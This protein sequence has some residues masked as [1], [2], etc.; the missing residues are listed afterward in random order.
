MDITSWKYS[1]KNKIITSALLGSLLYAGLAQ[2]HGG[3]G[4][5]SQRKL[6]RKRGATAA[7]YIWTH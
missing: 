6:K 4:R 3:F 1:T 7:L 5:Y 2:S